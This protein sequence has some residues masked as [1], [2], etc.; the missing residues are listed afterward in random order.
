M[1]QSRD[2][3][4]Q[5]NN[6]LREFPFISVAMINLSRKCVETEKNLIQRLQTAI[7]EA[8]KVL[9][10]DLESIHC[11]IMPSVGYADF[12]LLFLSDHLTKV[13]T[14]LDYLRQ[15]AVKDL[16]NR[17]Y[18]MLSN[19][20]AISGFAKVGL[21]GLQ[22]RDS[23]NDV[24]LSIRVN[25]RDGVSAS[26]FKRYFDEQIKEILQHSAQGEVL[27]SHDLY[28]VF[29]NSDCLI[30]SD[31]SFD[32]F[33]PLF[34][35]AKL[36][37]PAHR[38]FQDYIRHTRSSIRVE[39]D[40]KEIPSTVQSGDSEI[41]KVYQK[42]FR[43]LIDRLKEYVENQNLPVRTIN[44][45]QNVM[46]TYLNLVQFS[47]CF[48]I[49]KIVGDAF[50]AVTNNVDKTIELI[51]KNDEKA[52]WYSEQMMNALRIF[53]DKIEEY[54][55]DLLRSDRLFIEGQSL[56][57][58]SIGSATKLLFFYNKFLNDMAVKLL[59]DEEQK[60]GN[61]YTF[62]VTSGGCDVTTAC[63]VFSYLESSET[64]I[65][66][67]I[68]I[69][70][71]EMSLYD[72]R[73]TMFRLLHE[74]FHFCGERMR[75]LRQKAL[76][77]SI[78]ENTAVVI[79]AGLRKSLE[80]Q[81][82]ERVYTSLQKN[83]SEEDK[84]EIKA[85]GKAIIRTEVNLLFSEYADRI[86]RELGEKIDLTN[87]NMQYGRMVYLYVGDTLKREVLTI[88]NIKDP[89]TVLRYVYKEYMIC[90]GRVAERVI[91]CLKRKNV[92][93][94]KADILKE[95]ADHK[96]ILEKENI[97][98]QEEA[99][100]IR[101][102]FRALVE[103]VVFE[104]L[105]VDIVGNEQITVDDMLDNLDA[106]FKECFADCMAA[107]ILDLPIE[108]FVLCFI[109]ETWNLDYVFSDS[110]R[111]AIELKVLY[112]IADGLGEDNRQKILTKVSHWA[113]QGFCYQKREGYMDEVCDRI[114]MFLGEYATGNY[115]GMEVI[116]EY[117]KK[118]IGLYQKQDFTSEAKLGHLAD[119]RLPEEIHKL[120]ERIQSK[121]KNIAGN[122]RG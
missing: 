15:V 31:M 47:H 105:V 40:S 75:E 51:E 26:Q 89:K 78:A 68:I 107:Y 94:S 86:D 102:L 73:G 117:L 69:S 92:P 44:G 1:G 104:K 37:N 119:M 14:V 71:P 4:G 108:D 66:S 41:Y 64:G 17:T 30:L 55:A 34:Y 43:K 98:D 121:W 8:V 27:E 18:A 83:L 24:K 52:F 120:L 112:G 93:F 54:L 65:H 84:L 58:P 5:C 95:T 74:C 36:L 59:D 103:D 60:R 48:D 80:R 39:I 9:D 42:K 53:R 111:L 32:F 11:A 46:K 13:I 12:V 49:E 50:E 72:I 29:G 35:D 101:L 106:L 77:R 114:D 91:A 22:K 56:S 79:C 10:I 67:L 85:Q 115:V 45:L 110:L 99:K 7:M 2:D 38:L 81:F 97:I 16:S 82:D 19:S 70:I 100:V 20:Y 6:V 122:E 88:D 23:L 118:C 28:Q 116:E 109:Y 62:L 25:L 61:R 76:L 113:K 21:E 33:V 63:D 87:K 90:Q 96:K 3:E 57:H